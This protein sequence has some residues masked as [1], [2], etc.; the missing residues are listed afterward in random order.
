MTFEERLHPRDRHGRWASKNVPTEQSAFFFDLAGSSSLT[1]EKGDEYTF[2]LMTAVR[3]VIHGAVK[4]HGG[5]PGLNFGDGETALF[6]NPEEAVAAALEVQKNLE[7]V[8]EGRKDEFGTDWYMRASVV[9]KVS[10][11]TNI[12]ERV[13]GDFSYADLFLF[14]HADKAQHHAKPHEVV[15]DDAVA[16]RISPSL[17]DRV[18]SIVKSY[19]VAVGKFSAEKLMKAAGLAKGTMTTGDLGDAI[20]GPSGGGATFEQVL[21]LVRD[22]KLTIPQKR[23]RGKKSDLK[24]DPDV[25][26]VKALNEELRYTLGV[27]Y[28]PHTI[29]LH[30]E[31]TSDAEL[32]KGVM[33]YQLGHDRRLRLQHSDKEVGTVLSVFRWPYET[34]ITTINAQTLQKATQKLPP[35]SIFAE[36]M[37]D[38]EAW[39]LVKA[40]KIRGYSMGGRAMRVRFEEE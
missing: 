12:P 22:G 25:P 31:W 27:F 23:R 19:H 20:S 35:G 28:A 3:G 1:E 14:K 33:Q 24:V 10:R 13:F 15:V 9:G 29:D 39:P 2:K 36:V 8:R 17:R 11:G 16:K 6:D 40:G 30:G 7:A 38:P 32:H 4:R 26:Y 18:G 34:E 21:A 5:K 37:W